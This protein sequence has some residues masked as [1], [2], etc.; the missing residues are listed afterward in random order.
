V[1][2]LNIMPHVKGHVAVDVME[3]GRIVDH[4]E[5]DNYVSP[6]VYDALRKYV[7][8]HFM[9]LHDGTNLYMQGSA[10]DRY[11][12]N[13]VFI[14]TDYAGPVNTRERVIHGTPLSYGYHQHVSNNTNECSFN[15]VESYRKANSL[16]FVF[17][18]STSQGN[19]T[20]QSIYS[21]PST[22]NPNYFAGYKLLA[23]SDARWF[24]AYCDGKIYVSS[25]DSLTVFTVDDWIT[26]LNGGEWDRQTVQVPNAG[27]YDNTSLTAYNHSIYWVNGQSVCSAPV[28]DLT[29]V[30]T[31]NIGDFGDNISYSAIRNSF[32]ISISNTEVRE[33]STSFEVKK[34]FTGDYGSSFIAA[35]PEE[36]SVLIGTRVYDIDDNANALKPCARWQD[37]ENFFDMSFIG[38]FA[39]AHGAYT[40]TGLYLGTQYFSRARLDKPV[41][42]NSR[43]TMKITYDFNMPPIDWEH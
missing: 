35:M 6:F 16:R 32:F 24:T 34:T 33:Y 5:H 26:R 38:G 36:N 42:K 27:L 23:S 20:F 41:T 40:W 10:F 22:S 1:E 18:F 21:S 43:Q 8:A 39:L 11:A 17:D 19:G 29:N 25:E 30:T 2:R 3:D 7:N 28:S 37:A 9:M 31:H 12:L 4:A 14:L 13:S 15:Q